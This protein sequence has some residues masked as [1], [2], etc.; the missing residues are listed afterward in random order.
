MLPALQDGDGVCINPAAYRNLLQTVG[1]QPLKMI[2]RRGDIIVFDNPETTPDDYLIKRVIGIPGD[3][4]SMNGGQPVINGWSVPLCDA[5]MYAN[6][7]GDFQPTQGHLAVEFLDDH[8]YLTL[9]TFS[10]AVPQFVPTY[11]VKEHEVFVLG[12]NRH[13]SSDSRAWNNGYGGGV[14]ISSIRGRFDRFLVEKT[15]RGS[16]DFSRIFRPLDLQPRLEGVD[17]SQLSRR[18]N[19][20]IKKMP[21][22]S[23][24]PAAS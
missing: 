16:V 9:Y 22:Q 7:T 10:R 8:A 15:R 21:A 4:I 23:R 2:P 24:P 20:C 6:I 14:P 5:G 17:V 19:E 1:V 18:I 13:E 12:D 3:R 11:Q